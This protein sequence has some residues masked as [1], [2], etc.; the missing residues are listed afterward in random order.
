MAADGVMK[1]GTGNYAHVSMPPMSHEVQVSFAPAPQ[2]P[3]TQRQTVYTATPDSASWYYMPNFHGQLP[4]GNYSISFS[5]NFTYCLFFCKDCETWS[6]VDKYWYRPRYIQV[7]LLGLSPFSEKKDCAGVVNGTAYIDE[8]E[9]C[10]GGTTGKEPCVV[11]IIGR[12]GINGLFGAYAIQNKQSQLYMG[13][14]DKSL[15]SHALVV[16]SGYSGD[17]SQLFELNYLGDGY[18]NIV[19]VASRLPL[20]IVNLSIN[21]KA[22][23]EQWNG[24]NYSDITNEAGSVSAQYEATSAGESIDKLIDNNRI[25]KYNTAH[26]R[27]W[28]QFHSET[29][30]VVTRY[31]LTSASNNRTRDPE[32]WSLWGSDN[33][34]TW[35]KL[36]TI[37]DVIF[38]SGLEE[39][40]FDINNEIAYSYYRMDMECFSGNTLQLAEW[41][42]FVGVI[43]EEGV[44][45]RKFII[46]DAGND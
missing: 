9:E 39:K 8:C 45:N 30:K 36:D 19:N 32:N 26:G 4:N 24:L 21:P 7:D 18:Y 3:W 13:I 12:T 14:K 44:D 43:P 31:S 11:N 5:A 34:E 41:K 29:P 40:I 23:I 46:Q 38:Q 6:F 22:N 28:V 35:T 16:Q 1:I 20:G 17:E 10:V 2:G 25:T 37:G 15:E 27:A 33:E 42:L